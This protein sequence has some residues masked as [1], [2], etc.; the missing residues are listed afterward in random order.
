MVFEYIR[1]SSMGFSWY[2]DIDDVQIVMESLCCS[3]PYPDYQCIG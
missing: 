3:L 2:I 1:V